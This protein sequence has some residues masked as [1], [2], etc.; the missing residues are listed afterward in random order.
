MKSYI[1]LVE[2]EESLADSLSFTLNKDGY[3][4]KYVTSGIDA[5]K[6]INSEPP[7]LIIL[8]IMLPHLNGFEIC[9]IIRQNPT[10]I[11]IIM[12]TARGEEADKILGLETGADDYLVKPFSVKELEARIRAV[13]RRSKALSINAAG[14]KESTGK[15]IRYKELL[16]DQ[17][18]CQIFLDN[19]EL[20]LSPKEYALLETLLIKQGEVI[21]REELLET[22]W[23]KN[24][25]GDAKTLDVHIRWLREKIEKDSANPYYIITVKGKGYRLGT[26]Q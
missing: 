8:D 10:Y 11:P 1:L 13:L 15:Q 14:Q 25:I 24:F 20:A 21:Y 22:V 2:D 5:I 16:I 26:P 19:K 17:K 4:V 7:A 18:S 12:L 23:G 3:N 9:K 6:L